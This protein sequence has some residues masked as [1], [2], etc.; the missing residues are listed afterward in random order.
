MAEI[1][2]GG[3]LRIFSLVVFKEFFKFFILLSSSVDNSGHVVDRL[4]LD[5]LFEFFYI[6]YSSFT[7]ELILSIIGLFQCLLSFWYIKPRNLIE[8]LL[9]GLENIANHLYFDLFSP[10]LLFWSILLLTWICEFVYQEKEKSK[11][12]IENL[13]KCI[14][15]CLGGVLNR[16]NGVYV[17]GG[18]FWVFENDKMN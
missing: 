13:E 15:R 2:H 6:G 12:K 8:D 7:V 14:L 4:C 10:Q 9:C 5:V 1:D 3:K 11:E 16:R 17:L 18:T